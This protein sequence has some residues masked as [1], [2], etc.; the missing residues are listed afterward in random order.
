[1]A[2]VVLVVNE[3]RGELNNILV[4]SNRRIH[5]TECDCVEC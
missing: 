5:I 4:E 1:M 2:Y 3:P